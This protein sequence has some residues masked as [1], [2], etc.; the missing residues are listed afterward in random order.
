LES[1]VGKAVDAG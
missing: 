1:P